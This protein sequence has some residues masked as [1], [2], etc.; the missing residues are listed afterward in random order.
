MMNELQR[1][2]RT[3]DNLPDVQLSLAAREESP[4]ADEL[5]V[6]AGVVQPMNFQP[7]N[8]ATQQRGRSWAVSNESPPRNLP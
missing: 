7:F 3:E 4:L 6:N 1:S 2:L 8:D 5:G